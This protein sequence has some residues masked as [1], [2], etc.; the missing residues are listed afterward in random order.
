M[1]HISVDYNPKPFR[2]NSHD[3]APVNA[4]FFRQN[5]QPRLGAV[6]NCSSTLYT[7]SPS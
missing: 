1:F 4:T 3:Y 2:R 6:Q 7:A 5:H